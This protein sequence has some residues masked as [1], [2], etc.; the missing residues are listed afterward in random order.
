MLELADLEHSQ[1]GYSAFLPLHRER[2][3]TVSVPSG[4]VCVR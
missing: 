3:W 4:L 2:Y 1:G